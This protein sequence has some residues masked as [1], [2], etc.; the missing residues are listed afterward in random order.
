MMVAGKYLLPDVVDVVSSEH[1]RGF[2]QVIEI[3]IN[4]DSVYCGKAVRFLF[5]GL[6]LTSENFVKIR[7]SV[8]PQDDL[9]NYSIPVL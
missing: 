4:Q 5:E 7:R 1:T 3:K 8:S 6:G 9:P 2:T